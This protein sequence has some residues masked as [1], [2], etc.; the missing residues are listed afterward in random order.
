MAI[1][2]ISMRA[3][4]HGLVINII[5][6]LCTCSKP[7]L[8]DEC[9][10]LLRL[11]LDEFSLPKY[12]HLF[13]ISKVQSATTTAFRSAS[14]SVTSD[15]RFTASHTAGNSDRSS[16]ALS[17]PDR[18]RL[19]LESLGDITEALLEIMEICS[20]SIPNCN[21]LQQWTALSK[22]F[23]FRYNPALQPRGLVVFG[24][25]AKAITDQDVKQLLRILVKA[26]ESFSD[27]NLIEAI[28][29]CLTQL[30]PLLRPESP[31]HRALFWV[32][33]S[34]LQ[35]DEIS[36][37]ASGMA[38]LEQ[39]LLTLEYIGTFRDEELDHVMLQ[40]REPLQW[41]FKQLDHS[42]GLSFKNNFHFALVGHL[43][44]GYRHPSQLTV[45]R[46]TRILAMLLDI[47][48]KPPNRGGVQPVNSTK[49]KFEVT[50]SNVAYLAALVSVSEEVR[51]RCHV[52]HTFADVMPDSPTFDSFV[53]DTHLKTNQ[54]TN[55][56]VNPAPNPNHPPNALRSSGMSSPV[57]SQHQSGNKEDHLP[58]NNQQNYPANSRQKSLDGVDSSGALD[59]STSRP[60]N[61]NININ[62]QPASATVSS[63]GGL[64]PG[65]G[66]LQVGPRLEK[67]AN[68]VACVSNSS[69]LGTSVN[70]SLSED[71]GSTVTSYEQQNEVQEEQIY[72]PINSEDEE[73]VPVANAAAVNVGGGS[74]SSAPTPRP[75]IS[76]ENNI[77]LDPEIL[78][79]QVT[80]VLVLTVMATLVKY[81]TNESEVRILYEYLAEASVVFP[82][83]FPIIHSLLDAK[84]TNVLSLCHDKTIL[85]SVQAII[86]NMIACEEDKIQQQLHYLQSCGFGGLWRFA[87]KRSNSIR[88]LKCGVRL[89]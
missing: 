2:P 64:V 58:S 10:R 19:S 88:V 75:S 48:A 67:R 1:G 86:E 26:L 4:T 60:Q 24:C 47:V 31:I 23:A 69:L 16:Y 18:E 62:K 53:V 25:I 40:T 13:G 28:V 51:S 35:L 81:T 66:S 82:K 56:H 11:S 14:R 70:K 21:W 12:Y 20:P 54:P 77:L 65:H 49:E 33:I 71:H 52:R 42:V 78:T 76:N 34:I 43:I 17:P 15:G 37:Y 89:K 45:A 74:N 41:Y 44:K 38:L 8:T 59:T 6:S 73:E 36:L 30:Q 7:A 50:A 72:A 9:K 5:H 63:G 68:S 55:S 29:M 87:G 85:A 84:I 22:S 39:N 57:N 27:I 83:V 32:S 46:T 80:Q 79:D 3:S 61:S